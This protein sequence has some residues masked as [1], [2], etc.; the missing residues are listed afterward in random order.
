MVKIKVTPHKEGIGKGLSFIVSHEGVDQMF[1]ADGSSKETLDFIGV[2]IGNY[3]TEI[4]AKHKKKK[5][6]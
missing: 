5:K 1:I 3:L 4:M 2:E 6:K